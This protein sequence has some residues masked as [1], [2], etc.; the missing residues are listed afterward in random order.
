[1]KNGWTGGQY[2]IFRVIFGIYLCIH[3]AQLAPW[4]A[5]VFSN[6]GALGDGTASPFLY[7]FPNILA[8]VDSPPFVTGFVIA[9]AVLSLAFAFGWR[10]RVAA[11]L[12]WYIWACL[13]GRNPLISNPALP[14]VG[15][16]LLAHVFLP[17]APYGSWAA[18]GRVDPAGG[19]R[20]PAGIFL[21][22]WILMAVGYSYSGYTKLISP[23]WI[24]GTA[25]ARIFDNP[26]ARP[27]FLRDAVLQMPSGLLNVATWGALA[28]ELLFAPLVL[29]RRLRP[30]AWAAMLGMH[31]GLMVLIDF[32]DLSLGMAMLHLF[33]FNPAW[34]RPRRAEDLDTLFYD[35]T[36]GLC[37]RVVRFVLAEDTNG[38]RF[39]LA[40]LDSD[41]FREEIPEEKRKDLPD[42]VVVCSADGTVRVRSDAILHLFSRLG[43]AWRVLAWGMGL[44]PRPLRDLVYNFIA[45]IR[46]R[47]FSR[48][49]QACPILPGHLMARFRQRGKAVS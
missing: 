23:S 33:T 18:R 27:G 30:W 2:S 19:W 14:Y 8:L 44:V 43:G 37:H 35:G 17:A 34:I 46:H 22:A 28:L 32:A 11:F 31:C 36:C 47:L 3:F 1:M 20:M 6:Q 9:G 16:M 38:D 24:D 13:F 49:A 21:V 4:A 12:L 15:W 5:E 39:R 7:A 48:P 26:L 25:L 45:R 29:I 40:A 41:A 10:D 42:S